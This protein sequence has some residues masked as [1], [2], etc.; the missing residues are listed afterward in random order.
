VRM[1]RPNH[2]EK[3]L[4]LKEN[5]FGKKFTLSKINKEKRLALST[6]DYE[7]RQR[8][9]T[10]Q[11]GKSCEDIRSYKKPMKSYKRPCTYRCPTEVGQILS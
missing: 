6:S 7:K 9:H 3:K 1:W 10:I 11:W 2:E 4:R 5:D 8:C